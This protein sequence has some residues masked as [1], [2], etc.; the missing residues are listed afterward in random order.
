[1]AGAVGRVDLSGSTEILFDARG[2]PSLGA[3][4]TAEAF[5]AVEVMRAWS[6]ETAARGEVQAKL[7]EVV[8][9]LDR[10][11]LLVVLQADE[12][13]FAEAISA[14]FAV[15]T[16]ADEAPPRVWVAPLAGWLLDKV[17]RYVN[18]AA[19]AGGKATGTAVGGVIFADLTPLHHVLAQ[20]AAS[21]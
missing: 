11:Q 16:G 20:L 9:R 17:N 21:V 3:D 19:T 6:W 7:E 8:T 14:F 1:M 13:K 15:L 18:A 4:P 12:Q 10:S 2:D 5:V